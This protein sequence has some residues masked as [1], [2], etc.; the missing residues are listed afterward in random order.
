MLKQSEETINRSAIDAEKFQAMMGETRRRAYSMAIQLTRN[1]TDAE[2][3][4]QE[5][6]VKAWRGFESYA[7][8]RSFLNWLL[9]IMQR[10][11]LDSRRRENPVRK[12]ESLNALI[13]PHD[14]DSQELQVADDRITPD[15]ELLREEYKDQLNKALDQLPDVYSTALRMCDLEG[16]SYSEIADHQN[17]TIGTVRSRIHRGRRLLKEAIVRGGYQFR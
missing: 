6:Y 12:A 2:D 7:P 11:Y 1:A 16:L 3:L 13:T 17:T 8:D 10:A 4:V 9:R 5:T 14:R 15:E